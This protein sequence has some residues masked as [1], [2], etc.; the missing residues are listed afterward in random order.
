LP[1]DDRVFR[2]ACVSGVGNAKMDSASNLFAAEEADMQELTPA[3]AWCN[4]EVRDRIPQRSRNTTAVRL[5][6]L[7]RVHAKQAMA[8]GDFVPRPE[9]RSP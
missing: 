7:H 3:S 2:Y 1:A 5:I 9:R 8:P 6:D 4:G